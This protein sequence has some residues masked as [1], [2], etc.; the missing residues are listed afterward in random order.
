[1]AAVKEP[2]SVNPNFANKHLYTPVIGHGET[3]YLAGRTSWNAPE[4]EDI[5]AATKFVLDGL[6]AELKNVGSSMEKVL[7]VVVYLRDIEDYDG[8]NAMYEGRF[9]AV[10]PARTT[11]EAKLPRKSIVGVDITAYR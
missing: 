11:V 6:E 4:P 1:M 7:K 5:K 3:L 8:M 9:G 2:F 10:P